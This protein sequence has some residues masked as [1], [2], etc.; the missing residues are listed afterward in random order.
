MLAYNHQ[1]PTTFAVISIN[2]RVRNF[3]FPARRRRSCRRNSS[4]GQHIEDLRGMNF[5]LIFVG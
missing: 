1:R 5:T 2:M 4:G 3:P